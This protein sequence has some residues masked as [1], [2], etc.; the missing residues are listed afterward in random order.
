MLMLCKGIEK[1]VT[2]TNTSFTTGVTVNNRDPHLHKITAFFQ[3]IFQSPF[4]MHTQLSNQSMKKVSLKQLHHHNEV[5]NKS[6]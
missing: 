3:T 6:E 5:N 1:K 4:I 2:S